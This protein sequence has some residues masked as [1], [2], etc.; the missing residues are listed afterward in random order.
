MPLLSIGRSDE[1]TNADVACRRFVGTL[2][3]LVAKPL[4]ARINIAGGDAVVTLIEDPVGDQMT[5]RNLASNPVRFV[6]KTNTGKTPVPFV[7]ALRLPAHGARQQ[8]YGFRVGKRLADIGVGGGK[9]FGIELGLFCFDRFERTAVD[10]VAVRLCDPEAAPG[11]IDAC[12]VGYVSA[13]GFGL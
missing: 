12:F 8:L 6:A 3:Q 13:V 5:A 9:N 7:P 10:N 11:M 4:I 2:T 1:R